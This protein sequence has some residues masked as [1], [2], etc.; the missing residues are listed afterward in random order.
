MNKHTNA[1]CKSLIFQNGRNWDSVVSADHSDLG[2][3]WLV[4]LGLTAL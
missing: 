1:C 2:L 4:V 3:G